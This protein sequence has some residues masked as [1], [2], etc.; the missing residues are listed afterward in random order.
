MSRNSNANP[1]L[2]DSVAEHMAEG[3]TPPQI[4]TALGLT[5]NQVNGIIFRIRQGLGA[6]AC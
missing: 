1:G 5:K 3:F 2:V 6:Q 4:A